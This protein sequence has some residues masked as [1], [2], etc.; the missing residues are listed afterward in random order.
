MPRFPARA[1]L[2]LVYAYGITFGFAGF[3]AFETIGFRQKC[4]EMSIYRECIIEI[5]EFNA[6]SVDPDQMLGI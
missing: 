6:N 4:G 3:C 5:P 2:R 1:A